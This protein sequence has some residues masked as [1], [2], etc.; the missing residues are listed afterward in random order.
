MQ[1]LPET[2]VA[3]AFL[4]RPSIVVRTRFG[5]TN[6]PESLE[7]KSPTTWILST[8]FVTNGEGTGFAQDLIFF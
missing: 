2:L 6:F 4:S 8:G 5:V 3:L 7:K 1:K